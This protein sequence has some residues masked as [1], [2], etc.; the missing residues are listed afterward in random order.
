VAGCS[1]VFVAG[2]FRAR[3]LGLAWLADLPGDCGLLIP[4]CSSVHTFG[5]RFALDL[6]FLDG[7][8]AV[9]REV[10]AVP[11]W[12]VVRCRG[13][14]A[15][16]ERRAAGGGRRSCGL[17]GGADELGEAEAER[18]ERQVLGHVEL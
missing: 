10:K 5:M 13:A 15:V 14:S 6:A 11:P 18:L 12:R 3:L 17:D 8:G 4:R 7:G 2:T 9:L 1:L 16:L